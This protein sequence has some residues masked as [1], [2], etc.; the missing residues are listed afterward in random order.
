M[1]WLMEKDIIAESRLLYL[2]ILPRMMRLRSRRQMIWW[3]WTGLF[4]HWNV[5]V[6]LQFHSANLKYCFNI[7]KIHHFLFSAFRD[8]VICRITLCFGRLR[9]CIC[10]VNRSPWIGPMLECQ[11]RAASH[12]IWI[13]RLLSIFCMLD[14]RSWQM[15]FLAIEESAFAGAWTIGARNL[16]GRRPAINNAISPISFKAT[17]DSVS[18][19]K[20][21]GNRKTLWMEF[22]SLFDFVACQFRRMPS[23]SFSKSSRRR[24]AYLKIPIFKKP[25][26]IITYI[27]IFLWSQHR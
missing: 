2:S 11:Y 16:P 21:F 10:P 6:F 14:R 5:R 26:S 12:V 4:F 20:F 23:I 27:L 7:W 15:N 24:N 8:G 17:P 3:I 25:N 19:T 22:N 18:E 9:S 1:H 13:T